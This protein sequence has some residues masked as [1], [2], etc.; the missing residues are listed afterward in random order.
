MLGH[1]MGTL[2]LYKLLRKVQKHLGGLGHALSAYGE[3][4]RL[5]IL[6]IYIAILRRSILR[7]F[8]A[9]FA[10]DNDTISA[11]NSYAYLHRWGTASS[12]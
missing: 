6:W 9:P 5:V 2:R 7:P 4:M 12:C 1:S 3:L 8:S 10:I 11:D